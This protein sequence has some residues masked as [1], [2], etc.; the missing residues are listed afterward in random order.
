MTPAQEKRRNEI[1][2]AEK[3]IDISKAIDN[4]KRQYE[5]IIELQFKIDSLKAIAIKKDSLVMAFSN[6]I[7]VLNSELLRI[8]N[9]ENNVSDDELKI[10]KKPFLGF[11]SRARINLQ[12]LDYKKINF[13]INLSYDFKFVSLGIYGETFSVR[14]TNFSKSFNTEM[15]YGLFIEYKIF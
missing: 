7:S 1:F 3:I 13:S 11:H 5:T 6:Q 12:E 14:E 9:E 2:T 8:N 4:E 15:Y 10:A